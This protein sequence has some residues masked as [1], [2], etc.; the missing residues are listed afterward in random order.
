MCDQSKENQLTPSF[1]NK[2]IKISLGH[3]DTHTRL[4]CCHGKLI[5]MKKLTSK[6][7]VLCL[8]LLS[9]IWSRADTSRMENVHVLA[10]IHSI[11]EAETLTGNAIQLENDGLSEILQKLKPEDEVLLKGFVTYQPEKNDTQINMHPVFHIQSIHPVSLKRLGITQEKIAEPSLTFTTASAKGPLTIPVS[12]AV[13]SSITMTASILLLQNLT[14][15]ESTQPL[16]SDL[17]KATFLSAGIL[18]TGYFIWKQIATK[19][20]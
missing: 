8:L 2:L 18:A 13:A 6:I 3:D 9:S 12:T 11:K 4:I 15:A 20:D 10:R 16:K 1:K 19:H 5:P 14:Y 17:Q 7:L